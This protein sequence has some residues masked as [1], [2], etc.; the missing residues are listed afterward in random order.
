MTTIDWLHYDALFYVMT[1]HGFTS[2]PHKK[3]ESHSVTTRRNS[4]IPAGEATDPVVNYLCAVR[5][6]MRDYTYDSGRI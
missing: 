3:G 2:E 5:M 1:A 6:A 4:Y